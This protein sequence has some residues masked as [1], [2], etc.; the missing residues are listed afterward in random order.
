[1]PL[2]NHRLSNHSLSNH[3][4]L[5]PYTILSLLGA[6]GMGEVYLAEDTR[7]RR[8]VA[9]KILPR[10]IADEPDRLRRLQREAEALA[11]LNHPNIVTIYA[12]EEIDG[13]RLLA[14]ELV[15][16]K[17]LADLIPAGGLPAHTLRAVTPVLVDALG[18]A[19]RRGIIH[20]DLKSSNVMIN[21]E[22]R[23]KI[24][25]FGLARQLRDD[26]EASEPNTAPMADSGVMSGTIPYMAPECLRGEPADE[27]S[28]IFSL[29]V[30]I[31]EAAAGLR[32]FRGDSLPELMSSILRDA[33]VPLSDSRRDL[34]LGLGQ[35]VDRCLHKEPLLRFQSCRELEDQLTRPASVSPTPASADPQSES[36]KLSA[37]PSRR[38]PSIAVLPFTDLSPEG[39]QEY[40]CQGIVEELINALTRIEGVEVASRT[41]ALRFKNA[42][43]DSRE[44]GRRLN[45]STLLQGS[46]RKAENRLRITTQ[47]INVADGFHLSSERF[48][49]E[50]KDVFA[51]QDEIAE[52]TA[53]ALRGVLT[54]GEKQA[55]RTVRTT[56]P[57]A[58]DLYLRGRYLFHQKRRRSF[59]TARQLF[60][61]AIELDPGFALAYAGIA[62]SCSFLYRWWGRN[63]ADLRLATGAS[64]TAV[65]LAPDLPEAHSSRALALSIAKRNDQAQHEFEVAL[66]LDPGA[67]EPLYLYA[68][69]CF[70]LGRLEQAAELFGR[71]ARARSE[72]YQALILSGSAYLGLGQEKRGLEVMRRGVARAERALEID[73]DDARARYLGG[74]ALVHLG[75]RDR[76]LEWAARALAIDPED[77]FVQWNVA[78]V[79]SSAGEVET[80]IDLLEKAH[81]LGFGHKGWMEHD[82]D[83]DPLRNHPRFQALAGKLR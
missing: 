53:E 30:V 5:G 24:L 51:I 33:P 79:Q 61:R 29:G 45:V 13:L 66:E 7:L 48:D 50:L 27:R 46:V 28:D 59:A 40:F 57:Q 15:E 63:E 76:G 41:S 55:L 1:M 67:F 9:L 64:R 22:G 58:F 73:P 4:Q 23:V 75:D 11:A 78:C 21:S 69:I 72:D 47:L 38:K 62:D 37:L 52:A 32:P 60:Q 42:R 3:S 81:G 14:M 44:I 19:H 49:R 36:G 68:R 83:L 80:A 6:G 25:D 56:D 71:A 8:R 10:A 35:V 17:T 70:A 39:D 65:E 20:R 74:G 16:G 77:P 43:S 34:P 31:Y 26:A 82:P 18:A 54:D 2:S 12:V